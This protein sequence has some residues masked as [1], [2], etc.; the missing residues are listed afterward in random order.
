MDCTVVNSS[1]FQTIFKKDVH[2][3]ICKFNGKTAQLKNY[4]DGT[5][6]VYGSHKY[7]SA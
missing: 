4:V 1:H 7:I 6:N 3:L 2:A 5:C